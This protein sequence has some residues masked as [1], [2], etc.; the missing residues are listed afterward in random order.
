MG[1]VGEDCGP[2]PLFGAARHSAAHSASVSSPAA[3]T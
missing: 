3:A 2:G 1:K